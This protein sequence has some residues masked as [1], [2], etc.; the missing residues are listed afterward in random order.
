[1]SDSLK[2]LLD[3]ALVYANLQKLPTR[4]QLNRQTHQQLDRQQPIAQIVQHVDD[5]QLWSTTALVCLERV[6]MCKCGH[7][8]QATEGLY[9]EHTHRRNHS[10]RLRRLPFYP[11]DDGDLLPHRVETIEEHVEMCHSCFME[12]A[13]GGAITRIEPHPQLQLFKCLPLR[14]KEAA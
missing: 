3:E 9:E 13:I 12:R 8:S 10:R 1:M 6:Q 7:T 2:Q 14:K 11:D 4:Q 5:E